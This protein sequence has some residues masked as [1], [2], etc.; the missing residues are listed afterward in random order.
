[1]WQVKQKEAVTIKK[2]K[3]VLVK[4][5]YEWMVYS[6][7]ARGFD[8]RHW[9]QNS[10]KKHSDLACEVGDQNSFWSRTLGGSV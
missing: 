2:K 7:G 9:D 1:M 6:R 8:S 4:H 3:V 10:K 5:Y